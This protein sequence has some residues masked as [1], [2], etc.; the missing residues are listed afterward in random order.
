MSE[1]IYETCQCH[2]NIWLPS[3]SLNRNRALEVTNN[4]YKALNLLTLRSK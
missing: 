1:K 2:E 4:R 3:V